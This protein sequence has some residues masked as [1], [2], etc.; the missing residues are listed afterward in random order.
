MNE[1][2]LN[3]IGATIAKTEKPLDAEIQRW[4]EKGYNVVV[5]SPIETPTNEAG[6]FKKRPEIAFICNVCVAKRMMPGG[7]CEGCGTWYF[8]F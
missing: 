7:Q 4:Q 5:P 1:T 8:P 6:V 3:N 2:N